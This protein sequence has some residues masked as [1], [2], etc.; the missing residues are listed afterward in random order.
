MG[1]NGA[2]LVLRRSVVQ[3]RADELGGLFDPEFHSFNEDIELFW[4]AEQRGLVIRHEP[5]VR[6]HHALAGS[7]GGAYRFESRPRDVQTRIMANYR[8]T[9]WR[10][11]RSVRDWLGWLVGE[12][13][14]AFQAVRGRGPSGVVLYAKSW[15]VSLQTARAITR[16]RGRLRAPTGR[17]TRPAAGP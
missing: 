9:V 1:G 8:T 4:W 12:A 10:H 2:C 13:S 11:A 15:A 7:F 3:A 16:R 6:V 5:G 17:T 14:Y